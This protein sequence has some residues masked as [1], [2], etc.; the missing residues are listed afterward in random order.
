[1]ATLTLLKENIEGEKSAWIATFTTLL[2]WLLALLLSSALGGTFFKRRPAA[3]PASA[4]TSNAVNTT[5][6]QPVKSKFDLERAAR[7]IFLGL[8]S[9]VA[10]NQMLYGVTRTV[11]V[12]AWISFAVGALYLLIRTVLHKRGVGS[13]GML[14]RVIDVVALLTLAVLYTAMW[15]VAFD[16][17]W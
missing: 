13:A 7:L 8:F 14:H 17:R 6:S 3:T 10:V 5:T 16:T 15:S 4:L 11:A 12:L 9:S 1:M 2:M